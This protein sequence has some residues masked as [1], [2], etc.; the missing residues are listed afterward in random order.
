MN[1]YQLAAQLSNYGGRAFSYAGR[2][3][4]NLLPENVRKST[5]TAIF[6]PSLKTFLFKQIMHSAH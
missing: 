4:W 5:S 2:H 6:K 3:A 1:I